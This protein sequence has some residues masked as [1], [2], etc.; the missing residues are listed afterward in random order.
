MRISEAVNLFIMI[1]MGRIWYWPMHGGKSAKF[2]RKRHKGELVNRK[3]N[4]SKRTSRWNSDL[5]EFL[6]KKEVRAVNYMQL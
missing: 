1:I 5:I 6:G 2:K 4:Q 3:F